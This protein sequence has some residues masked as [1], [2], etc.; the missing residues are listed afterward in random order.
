MI[1]DEELDALFTTLGGQ[2]DD[3]EL[4][5]RVAG[6]RGALRR[7]R[8][9]QAEAARINALA[10]DPDDDLSMAAP[11]TRA[12]EGDPV[13]WD[14]IVERYAPLVW[15]ICRRFQLSGHEAEDVAQNVWLRLVEH[16]GRLRDPAA[17]PGWL[18]T[19]THRECLRV[20]TAARRSERAGTKLGETLQFASDTGIEEAILAAERNA[21]WRAAFAELPP[22]CQQLLAMLLADPPYSYAEISAA[23]S[24]PVGSIGPQRARCLQR[25]RRS[26]VAIS[27]GWG[28]GP[29]PAPGESA[30]A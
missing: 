21:A 25:L 15:S 28:G 19:T 4:H 9:D 22:R 24:I 27:R 5:R 26:D 12:A 29:S 6:F 14:E 1:G 30:G 13:A 10:T 3:A 16:C 11:V 7:L 17:L 2:L 20:V 8:E 23:L 18:A